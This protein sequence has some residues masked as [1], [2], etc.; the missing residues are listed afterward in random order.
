MSDEGAEVALVNPPRKRRVRG[1]VRNQVGQLWAS[2]FFAPEGKTPKTVLITSAERQEGA[3]QIAAALAI[4]GAESQSELKF[5]LVDFNLH[6]PNLHRVLHVEPRIG[7]A[8]VIRGECTLQE[9]VHETHLPN[10][11]LIP[12]GKALRQPLGLMRSARAQ[13][14]L[15]DLHQSTQVD[16][17]I[18][19]A[20]ATNTY[21]EAQM[22]AP[23]VDGVVL[24]AWAGV[25]RRESVAEAKKRIEQNQGRLLGVVLNQRRY[26][27]PGFIYRRV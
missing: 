7:L 11:A 21:P 4:V 15:A 3:T 12:A 16:H 23:L 8:E 9:A 18:I 2:I 14:L 26:A 20:A 5:V 25:T 19:D 13:T 22:L 17:V 10:L 6:H 24:V 27:I 1:S